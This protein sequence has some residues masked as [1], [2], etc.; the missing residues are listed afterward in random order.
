MQSAG[1]H[2]VLA[3]IDRPLVRGLQAQGYHTLFTSGAQGVTALTISD[4]DIY[5]IDD[6]A[7]LCELLAEPGAICAIAVP[8]S[9]LL[10]LCPLI[11]MAIARRAMIT[12][13]GLDILLCLN[14]INAEK[15]LLDGF[16]SMMAGTALEYA[17]TRVG[18]VRAVLMRVCPDLPPTLAE[19]DPFGILSNGFN[20]L[21]LNA[22]AF[23]NAPPRSGMIRLTTQIDSEVLRKIYTLNMADAAL[24][25]LG[26]A[27][28]YVIAY[29]AVTDPDIAR[30]LHLALEE[31]SVGLRGECNFSQRQ[32]QQWN[33][34][35]IT[36]LANPYLGDHL[37]RLGADTARKVRHDDRIVGPALLCM[38]YGGTPSTLAKILAYAYTYATSDDPG[39]KRLHDAIRDEGIEAALERF[40]G[41]ALRNPFHTMVREEYNRLQES[42]Q[43]Q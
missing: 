42:L 39:T 16:E 1:Y 28:G 40:S 22:L 25:Y 12:S 38:K 18:L 10:D 8:P 23:K 26:V 15:T 41:I 33:L 7:T 9:A 35:V 30:V 14:D 17:R 11:C 20:E 37:R 3:D 27:K 34:S 19:T 2:V 31:A 43:P 4:Y 5:D 13:E 36:M 6:S 24:A 32:M 29:D 21:P